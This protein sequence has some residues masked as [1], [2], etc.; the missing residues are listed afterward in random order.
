MKGEHYT[1]YSIHYTRNQSIV[2]ERSL[3]D[4]DFEASLNGFHVVPEVF[5]PLV[6]GGL[7]RLLLPLLLLLLL[8]DALC[9]TLRP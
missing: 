6:E 4:V 7:P 2:V 9:S 3:A 8:D 5:V 1:L